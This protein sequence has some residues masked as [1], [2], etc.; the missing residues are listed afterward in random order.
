MSFHMSRKEYSELDFDLQ[1]FRNEE[2]QGKKYL[3]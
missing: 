2:Q 1:N 3:G